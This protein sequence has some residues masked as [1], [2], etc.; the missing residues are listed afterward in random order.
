MNAFTYMDLLVA[1]FS[2]VGA[3]VLIMVAVSRS[4]KILHDEITQRI[5]QSI[6]VIDELRHDR[7]GS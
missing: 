3:G 6:T 5:E 4:P 1:L 7:H 2:V